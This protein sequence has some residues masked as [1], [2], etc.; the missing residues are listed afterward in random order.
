MSKFVSDPRQFYQVQDPSPGTAIE[1]SQLE[2]D[3]G[4][5]KGPNPNPLPK[6]F[7]PL[8]LRGFEAKNRIWVSPMCMYSAQDGFSTDFHLA[9]YSQFAMRGAGL[10]MVEATGVLPEGRISPNC[11]GIW[12]DEHIEGLQRIVSHM[13]KYGTLAG[14]QLGHGGRKGSTIPLQMY[15]ARS[16]LRSSKEEGGWPDNV[17]GPSAEAYDDAHYTPK[18]MTIEQIQMVKQAFVDA[19]VRADKAGFDVLEVHSAHGYLLFEFLSPLSNHRTDEYGGSFENRSRLLLE[20]V[21][22]IRRVWPHEKPLFV[23]VSSTD[24]VEGG[25]TMDDTE[26]LAKI[27]LNAGVDLI[28]CS[29]AGNDPRQKIPLSPGY[30]VQFAQ[31]VKEQVPGMLSGAVGLISKGEQAREIIENDEADAIFVGREFLRNPS[32]VLSTAHELGINV[33]WNNQYERGRLKTKYSF[34]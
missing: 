33:K 16:S 25:W 3:Q 13:H 15:G 18:E 31:R 9:H 17:Y 4:F 24:W 19:A 14:I 34:V 30:Q 29:S 11:L 2:I 28:D 6:L 1:P 8:K 12:Q 20:V 26:A 10:V 7:Q 32:F 27:L 5:A 21:Q 23:R 22:G